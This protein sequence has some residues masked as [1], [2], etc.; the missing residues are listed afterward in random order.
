VT[1]VTPATIAIVF[2]RSV[3]RTVS[4]SPTVEG[5]PAQGYYIGSIVSD[6]PRVEIVGPES[7]V[8]YIDEAVTE[9]ISVESADEP[10]TRTVA[11]GLLDPAIRLKA[12]QRAVVSVEILPVRRTRRLSNQAVELRGLS[13]GLKALAV[14]ST[15]EVEL[16]ESDD[17]ADARGLDTVTLFVDLTGLGAGEYTMNIE[18]DSPPESGSAQIDPPALVVHVSRVD[19]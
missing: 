15:V 11:L 14:P 7:S 17:G 19:D 13:D 6:P 5:T 12:S 9:T 10:I 1:Q 3:A 4:V 16:Q 18:T 2:E 8:R